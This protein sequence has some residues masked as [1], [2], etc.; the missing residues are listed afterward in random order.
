MPATDTVKIGP[1]ID[2]DLYEEFVKLAKENGQS[3]RF[4]LESAIKHYLQFIA[5]LKDTIRPEVMAQ[6]RRSTNKNRKL[7]EVLARSVQM[8]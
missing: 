4:L 2:R 6:F 3:Q 1:A 8:A 5:P 7:H